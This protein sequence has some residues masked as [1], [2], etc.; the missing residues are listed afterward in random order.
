[1]LGYFGQGA[2]LLRDPKVIENPF[3][4]LVPE[5]WPTLLSVRRLLQEYS[6]GAT[7]ARR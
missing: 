3:F 1:V 2:L 4:A 6:S 7:A 5:G